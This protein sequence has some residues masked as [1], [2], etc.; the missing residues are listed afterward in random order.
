MILRNNVQRFFLTLKKGHK[1]ETFV[2]FENIWHFWYFFLIRWPLRVTAI[3]I[4]SRQFQFHSR[5]FRK[6][7]YTSHNIPF[8]VPKLVYNSRGHPPFSRTAS[9]WYAAMLQG[10]LSERV[11]YSQSTFLFIPNQ[12]FIGYLDGLIFII[13]T[14]CG[15]A[16]FGPGQVYSRLCVFLAST[17]SRSSS[18]TISSTLL[19]GTLIPFCSRKCQTLALR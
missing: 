14:V 9:R 15:Q 17:P 2:F 1:P 18:Q 12:P 7:L 16:L 10:R 6:R 13:I 19:Q 11:A 5:Q 8:S 3:S 4:Y